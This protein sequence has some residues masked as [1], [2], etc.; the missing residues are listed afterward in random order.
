MQKEQLQNDKMERWAAAVYLIVLLQHALRQQ[1]LQH[2]GGEEVAEEVALCDEVDDA[3]PG[4]AEP[5]LGARQQL[6]VVFEQRLHHTDTDESRHR[7]IAHK[8]TIA[9]CEVH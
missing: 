4:P 7:S 3:C 8:S 6:Q 5:L 1:I 9:R 2:V